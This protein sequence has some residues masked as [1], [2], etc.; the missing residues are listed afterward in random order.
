MYS[1]TLTAFFKK[2]GMPKVLKCVESFI[3]FGKIKDKYL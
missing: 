1:M 3:F 2:A